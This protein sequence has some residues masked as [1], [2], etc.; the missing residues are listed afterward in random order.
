MFWAYRQR[1][2]HPIPPRDLVLN[3][4]GKHVTIRFGM[5]LLVKYPVILSHVAIIPWFSDRMQFE[6]LKLKSL[7]YFRLTYNNRLFTRNFAFL[8]FPVR[9]IVMV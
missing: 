8:N 3:S 9:A 5:A 6:I 1:T 4:P 7:Y 2:Y